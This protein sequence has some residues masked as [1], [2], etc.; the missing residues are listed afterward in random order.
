VGHGATNSPRRPQ[1]SPAL[2]FSSL[3]TGFKWLVGAV[4]TA[5]AVAAA[6]GSILA[7]RPKP[8]PELGAKI[9]KL[10]IDRNVTLSEYRASN[11]QASAFLP[12]PSRTR[13]FAADY[14]TLTKTT[15][16]QSTTGETTTGETT[17][18]ETTTGET[19]TG[20]TTTGETTTGETTTGET[21]TGATTTEHGKVLPLLSPAARASL[22]EGLQQALNQP[23]L[24]IPIIIGPA[25]SEDPSDPNCGLGSAM[26]YIGVLN[27]DGSPASVDSDLVGDHLTELLASSRMQPI[28]GGQVPV[29]VT[30]NYD[31]SLTGFRGR[32]VTIRWSLRGPGGTVP[33]K[34]LK[35]EPI[36]WL[37]G[38]ADK[39]SASDSFWVPIPKAK[40]PFKVR[41]GIYN[42]DNVRL[43]FEDSKRFQ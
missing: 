16:S 8:T 4:I 10:S 41:L 38:E 27:S 20:E 9:T 3:S 40:G 26:A 15:T 21:T 25:C 35:N 18:G 17:T 2:W 5:G 28:S 36:H 29:G 13:D 11:E 19:T 31:I 14:S 37:R 30:V 33:L 32:K 24:A 22:N 43:D 6:I 34:W 39:D 42:G 1:R 7:L 12:E 23:P